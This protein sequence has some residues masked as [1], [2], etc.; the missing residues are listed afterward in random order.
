MLTNEKIEK[1]LNFFED[2]TVT[3]YNITDG[4]FEYH[5]TIIKFIDDCYE[6]DMLDSNYLGKIKRYKSENKDLKD[7]IED[8]DIDLLKSIL[9]FYIRGERFCD[10]MIASSFEDEIFRRILS[11]LSNNK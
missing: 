6:S 1:Y 9:T 11:R 4:Y 2:K 10:G 5:D 7:L 8:A 3:F